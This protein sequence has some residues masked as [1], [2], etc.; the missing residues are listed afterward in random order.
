MR[1][2]LSWTVIILIFLLGCKKDVPTHSLQY[3]VRN[4]D[5]NSVGD[6]KGDR[7]IFSIHYLDPS[8][9]TVSTGRVDTVIWQ[10]ALYS[11]VEEGTPLRIWLEVES[12]K[13]NLDI[14]IRKDNSVVAREEVRSTRKDYILE[15]EM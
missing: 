8:S 1:S 13:P 5:A 10:S 7:A 11:E 3:E 15:D 4:Y 12:G 6:Y 14:V 2:S 9:A